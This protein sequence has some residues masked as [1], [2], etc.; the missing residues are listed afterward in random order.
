MKSVKLPNS[1][2]SQAFAFAKELGFRIMNDPYKVGNSTQDVSEEDSE[3]VDHDANIEC[4]DDGDVEMGNSDDDV[5]MGNSDDDVQMGN[6]G[7]ESQEQNRNVRYMKSV[8]F[9][10]IKLVGNQSL[11]SSE[12]VDPSQRKLPEPQA[13]STPL[14]PRKVI[15]PMYQIMLI[16]M[17]MNLCHQHAL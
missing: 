6:S 3:G 17:R 16:W 12:E 11:V 7:D 2:E 14:K 4:E 8:S 13:A 1:L 5:E 15:K 9:P 10:Q